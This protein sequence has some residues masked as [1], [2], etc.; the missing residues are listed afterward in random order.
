MVATRFLGRPVRRFVQIVPAIAAAAFVTGAVEGASILNIASD[1]AN[2]AE[3]LGSFTGTIQY[4][5]DSPFSTTGTLMI[6]L[7]NTSDASNGGYITGFL[8]NIASQDNNASATLSN[9]PE[10][11]HAFQ[12]CSGNGLNG[13]PFGNPFDAGAALGGMYLGGGNPNGGIAVGATG[14]FYFTVSASDAG[15]LTAESFVTGG[16][17]AFD[18][19]VRFRGFENGGSDKVPVNYTVV[20]LPAPVA[21]G[22]AGIAGVGLCSRSIRRRMTASKK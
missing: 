10:P 15:I 2:S 18:F 17:Y 13:Q 21:M 12:N 7:T 14:T 9:T 5:T 20:P 3:G 11:T 1:N 19:I 22:L 16:G 4:T 6:S 8:F